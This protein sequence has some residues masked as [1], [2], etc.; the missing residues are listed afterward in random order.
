MLRIRF[1]GRGGQGIKTASQ[2]LG[3]A[4]FLSG[5]QAQDFPLYGAERRGAPIVAFTRIH[6]GPILERGVIGNPDLIL[7]GDETL[8]DDPIAAP[9]GGAEASTRL[10]INSTH[11]A[12]ALK[13]HFKLP[14]LPAALDLTA[15]CERHL[16]K[17]LVLSTALA[18]AAARITGMIE[19]SRL[20]EAIKTELAQL[21]LGG[22]VVQRNLDLADET[23]DAISPSSF[24]Q[25]GEEPLQGA[26]LLD[27]EQEEIRKSAP[28]ILQ[29]GNMALRKT[30]NWRIHHPAIDYDRCNA[31]WICFARC[32]DGA[33]GVGSDG[34][35]V[36]DYDHCKGCL[37]CAA[38]CP[39]KAIEVSREVSSWE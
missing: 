30:G 26:A 23:F 27:M 5:Y 1:H 16:Q 24:I 9:L 17:G 19:R 29:P 34:K 25:R 6:E 38:E 21:G 2:I 18:T 31:C 13:D 36:I 10:F 20:R 22:E 7:I 28:L 14:M 8:V 35:P 33:M 15:L 37:I 12:E 39:L 4:A 3:S 11:P 32:P